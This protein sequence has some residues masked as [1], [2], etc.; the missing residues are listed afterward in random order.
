[1][2]YK[3]FLFTISIILMAST[4]LFYTQ[5]YAY[6][7]GMSEKAILSAA[8][9][10]IPVFIADDIAS[11][12]KNTIRVKPKVL[13]SSSK[14]VNILGEIYYLETTNTDLLNYSQMLDQNFFLKTQGSKTLDLSNLTDG[15]AEV[16]F[17]NAVQLDCNYQNYVWLHPNS[18]TT[19]EGTNIDINIPGGSSTGY[20]WQ[21]NSTA[22]RSVS[23]TI[24][25][26]DD[27]QNFSVSNYVNPEQVSTFKVFYADRNAI[28]TIGNTGPNGTTAND[29]MM[30][31][32]GTKRIYYLIS[33]DYSN[34]QNITPIYVNAPFNYSDSTI[35]YGAPITFEK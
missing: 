14:I 7:T 26:K 8:K 11:D 18:P 2:N 1:M 9:N 4:L 29:S 22:G 16:Y 23:V 20:L 30:I 3:G 31:T 24:T 21:P 10:T 35:Q 12:I 33:A 32:P 17:N 13:Y 19:L 15:K 25:F 27:A 6:H 5:Q 34:D 28:M